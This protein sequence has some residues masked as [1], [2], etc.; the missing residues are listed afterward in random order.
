VLKVRVSVNW[1]DGLFAVVTPSV[2][3]RSVA[4]SEPKLMDP[5]WVLEPAGSP[6]RPISTTR[7]SPA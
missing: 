6:A 3:A 2:S 1:T 7:R 4:E 5:A